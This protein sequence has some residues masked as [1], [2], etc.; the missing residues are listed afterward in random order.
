MTAD[1]MELHYSLTGGTGS[2]DTD[3]TNF[4]DSL[5]YKDNVAVIDWLVGSIH[6]IVGHEAVFS[7]GSNFKSHPPAEDPDDPDAPEDVVEPTPDELQMMRLES[8][9]LDFETG[10]AAKA[11]WRHLKIGYGDLPVGLTKVKLEGE[12]VVIFMLTEEY[13]QSIADG[14]HDGPRFTA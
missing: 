2:V 13:I 1:N 11:A 6:E 8:F 12:S 14:V 7:V 3:T 9:K 4:L 5:R 10:K